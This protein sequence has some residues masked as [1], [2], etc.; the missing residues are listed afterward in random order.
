M[1]L[2]EQNIDNLYKFTRQHYVEHYDVQTELVDH[3]ANDI[4]KILA[5]QPTLS[6]EQARD[7]SFKK[8]GIFG[9]MDVV[10]Q[11]IVQLNKKY[12]RLILSFVKQWFR[13][14]KIILTFCFIALFYV[15]QQAPSAYYIY[16]G[17]FFSVILL[18][19]I[20]MFHSKRK[21]KK[22][23]ALTGKKW[24]LEDIYLRQSLGNLAI[25]MFYTYDW[26]LPHDTGFI[27]M[28]EFSRW[29][30]AALIVLIIL[31]GYITLIVIPNK[32]EELLANH[33][34]EYKLT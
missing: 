31:I 4:E 2:T 24:L 11:K 10:D 9:F 34:P 29:F 8:F 32:S 20:K 1:K 28:N 19:T 12:F 30:S 17:V 23:E 27:E 26:F 6:F 3:L 13:L 33:Y 14:P 18:E 16:T 7:V 22:K 5:E 15:L 25:I 21:I